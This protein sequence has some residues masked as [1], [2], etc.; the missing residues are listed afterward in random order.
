M[1]HVYEI[2]VLRRRRTH[3][4]ND[5]KFPAT[6]LATRV[7]SVHEAYRH[8]NLTRSQFKDSDMEQAGEVCEQIDGI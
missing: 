3:D 6:T 1:D 5:S 2:A 8:V 7:V 4:A